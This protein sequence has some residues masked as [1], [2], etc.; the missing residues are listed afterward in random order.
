[1]SELTSLIRLSERHIKPA[2][3]VLS[4]AFQ[5]DP[6]IR[7]QIPDANKRLLKTHYIFEIKLRIGVKYGEVYS[8]SKNLEGIAIWR[9]YKNVNYPY[10]QYLVRGGFKLPLKFGIK[11]AKRMTFVKAV[12]DSMR[13]IYMKVPYW[14]FELIGVDPKFQGQGFANKLIKPMLS[15]IDNKNLPIYLETTLE[16]NLLFF[17]YFEFEKLEEIIIPNTNIVHWSMIRINEE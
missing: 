3:L 9:S 11:N 15:R 10:W 13:N 1:M 14:Y 4:R 17:E 2:S 5:N 6:I 7:W 8:T 12:N 16:R